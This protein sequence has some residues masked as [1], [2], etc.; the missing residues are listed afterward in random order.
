MTDLLSVKNLKLAAPRAQRDHKK[1][2][3]WITIVEDISFDLKKGQVLGLIGES[4]A[5]K[6][7][8]GLAAMAYGRG[9]VEIT[10]GEVLL[11]GQD[12]LKFRLSRIRSLRGTKVCYVAQSAA[13]AFNPAHRIGDQVIEASVIHGLMSH[14]EA[15]KRARYLFGI[16]GLPDPEHF[17]SRFPHQVSGGQLQRA[18][19]AMALCPKPE[20]VIFDEPTTAL[21]VTTQIEV[22]K[23]IK[24]AIHISNTAALYITHDL[25]VVAQIAD[26]IMVLRHGRMV[27]YDTVK[28]IIE[29]PQQLY[30]RDLLNI[31]NRVYT[32]KPETAPVILSVCNVSAEYAHNVRVLDDVSLDIGKGKTVAIVGESGSGKSTLARVIAGLLPANQGQV[33]FEG[34][35]LPPGFRKRSF[36]ELRR[37]QL[38]YQMADTALNP[39]QTVRS[40]IGAPLSLYFG[41]RGR[42]KEHRIIELLEQI[43]LGSAFLDR[44]PEELSGGQKQ[45]V[46]I[47]RALAAKPDLILCDEPTSALD[48][49]VAE[50]I[51]DLLMRLQDETQVSY[52]FITHDLSVVKAIADD[53][54]VMHGG[55]LIRFGARD[56]ALSPPFDPYTEK[57]LK[58]VPEMKLGWLEAVLNE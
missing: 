22:L 58:S 43:E 41:L 3:E 28:A 39:K 38:I 19:T 49:L 26:H 29:T 15:Q 13:A 9:G 14:A 40:I 47:A 1:A 53:V 56:E 45:R 46:A 37:I 52:L 12:I 54:G 11:N 18:M 34:R 51:L 16:L 2:D 57:L 31:R 17:G 4:G 8:I 33:L 20:L 42:E 36:E 44:K 24:E 6:S 25:A 55:K 32:S 10:G 23:A 35:A 21:D 7:S 48:P 30:T 50:G 5:G 27:E